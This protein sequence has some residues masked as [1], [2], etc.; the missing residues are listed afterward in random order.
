MLKSKNKEEKVPLIKRFTA[1][2]ASYL[3]GKTKSTVIT[4]LIL[5]LLVIATLII[6]MFHGNYYNVFL[7][8]LT[9]V[10]FLIPAIA[11]RTLHIELP[12]ALEIIIL[13]FIFSA[14]I[15][16]EIQNFYGFFKTWD[17]MLHTMNGFMMAAIGFALIDI[18][19]NDPH[20]HF[21]ASPFFVAFV[22]FCFSMTVGVVWEFFEFGMDT[23]FSTDMQKD[24]IY[25]SISTVHTVI[26]PSG[27]NSAV[28]VDNVKSVITGTVNGETVT[29]TYDG[30]LD[31]GLKDTMKDLMVN[32]LGAIIFSVLGVFYIKGRSKVAELFMPRLKKNKAQS[33]ESSDSNKASKKS[34]NNSAE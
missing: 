8:V 2:L 3:E 27:E 6:Q 32:C 9:L 15:L 26:N 18:L 30:Y 17:T 19:N 12:S 13:L 31:I 28:I 14:E 10:L 33:A 16:G 25:D 24:F 11:D 20:F 22:A 1:E 23:F 21:T 4:Y 34:K 5:R 7:C 29:Y